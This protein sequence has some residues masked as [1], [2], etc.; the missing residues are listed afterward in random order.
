MNERL[1][2]SRSQPITRLASIDFSPLGGYDRLTD[3][4]AHPS[5]GKPF[6]GFAPNA[7]YAAYMNIHKVFVGRKGAQELV[8]IADS[9]KD[10]WLPDYLNA[11]GWAA[12]EA[13]LVSGD[14]QA[15]DRM[16]LMEQAEDCW[17]RALSNQASLAESGQYECLCEDSD[18]FRLALN[19][20]FTPLMKSI[21]A[22]D[23]TEATRE[24][25][26]ADVL[27]IA[28]TSAVQLKLALQEKNF[29]AIA[30]HLGFG[31]ECNA[32][33]ALLYLNN[34][35]YVPIPSTYRAGSGYEYRSQTHDIT[36]I[37]QNWGRI[38]RFYPVEIKA[39]ASVRDRKRYEALLV[40][41]KMHLSV[42]GKY[43]PLYTTEAFATCFEGDPTES[44]SNM[45][46]RR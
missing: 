40:R 37:N 33:L 19:L 12:A 14:R 1:E 45:P 30:D 2:A 38:N 9:L 18:E 5:P 28:Q 42:E 26:F 11:G 7:Q 3:A 43:L 20:A 27:A 13:A 17:Q 32:H 15:E 41:G 16:R 6:E 46:H 22:G 10:E 8:A 44:L 25:T 35:N 4:R 23:I 31:Y 29:D 24:R 34:P 39:A 36:I 21:I